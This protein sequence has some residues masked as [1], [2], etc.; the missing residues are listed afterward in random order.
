MNEEVKRWI[1]RLNNYHKALNRLGEIVNEGKR[2]KL[3]DFEL[4]SVVQRFEFTHETAWKLMKSYA[5]YQG[6]DDIGGSRDA[7]RRA[8]DMRLI[9]DGATWMEMIK[10]RN[11]TSHNYDGS[12]AD[13]IIARITDS[14]Y[15]LMLSFYEKMNALSELTENDIFTK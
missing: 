12:V 7:T 1:Q 2:R 14:Y 10:S 11:E 13:A 4:D 15:P 8:Y 3:N 6:Y 5:E 9:E